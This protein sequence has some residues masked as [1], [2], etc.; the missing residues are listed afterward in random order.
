MFTF[1]CLQSCDATDPN[2]D[3][4]GRRD[5]TW[6]VD[7]LWADDWFGVHEVWGYA[8]NSIWLVAVGTSAKDCLWHYDG[9]KWTESNQVLNPSLNTI[10]GITNEEIWIGDTYGTIWRNIGCWLAE[11]SEIYCRRI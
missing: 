7:A 10:F 9:I 3:L 4:P 1:Y 2:N 8:P 11:I 5:Y 6:T